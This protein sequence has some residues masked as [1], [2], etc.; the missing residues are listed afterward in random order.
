MDYITEQSSNTSFNDDEL[1]RSS[2]EMLSIVFQLSA[3]VQ[4]IRMSYLT[5]LDHLAKWGAFFNLL[6]TIFAIF[7]L[8]YNRRKFYEKN[9]D[10]EKFRKVTKK[11]LRMSNNQ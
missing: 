6:F 11:K 4:I 7:L 5:I 8:G 1:K 10:W 2:L 3:D 9:P